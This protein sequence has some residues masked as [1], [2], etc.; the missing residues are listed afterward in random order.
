[1][2]SL[3]AGTASVILTALVGLGA[4]QNQTGAI[5]GLI[6]DTTGRVLPGA[7]ITAVSNSAGTQTTV[8][9]AAGR[10]RLDRLPAGRY[11]LRASMSG[12]VTRMVETTVAAG[13]EG[14]WSGALLVGRVAD[15]TSIERRVMGLAGPD[16]RDCGRHAAP[17]SEAALRR[18]LECAV[19]SARLRRP[20]S[21]V[22]QFTRDDPQAGRGLFA[23][24]DGLIRFF[25]YSQGGAKF[26]SRDCPSPD[27]SPGRSR[28]AADFEFTCR[29]ATPADF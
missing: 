12:F 25:E 6:T 8:T 22:V 27:I 21:V 4:R 14:D 20:F 26:S 13:Q 5:S 9:D 28:S 29:T 7:A 15:E 19:T 10:Y 18:S 3:C 23:G 2:R 16:A 1:M 11:L 24:P 17:V